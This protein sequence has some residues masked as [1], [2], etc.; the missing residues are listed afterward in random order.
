MD[1]VF[2]LPRRARLAAAVD[3]GED[4]ELQLVGERPGQEPPLDP[5]ADFPPL[6]DL[7]PPLPALP[8][9]ARGN[10]SESEEDDAS[11]GF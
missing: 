11:D 8:V 1:V 9:A 6:D 10:S 7:P 5:L 2:V 4:W 3:G